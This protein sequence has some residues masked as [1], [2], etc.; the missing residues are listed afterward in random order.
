MRKN[1]ADAGRL[2][3]WHDERDLREWC[4]HG[5]QPRQQRRRADR[6]EPVVHLPREQR[7]RRGEDRA[8]RRVARERGRRDRPVR[9]DDVRHGGCEDEVGGRA[10]RDCREYRH[11]PM[12]AAVRC[13]RQPEEPDRR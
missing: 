7:E 8:H 3:R 9:V 2:E 6:T 1:G 10:E 13:E 11:D 4:H 5:R 12:H